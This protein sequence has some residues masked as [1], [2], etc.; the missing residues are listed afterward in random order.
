MSES[1]HTGQAIEAESRDEQERDAALTR[2]AVR[3]AL[4]GFGLMF[5]AAAFMWVSIGP[6]I[7]ID[8]ATAVMNCF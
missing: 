6:T 7:F 5:V 2:L 4:G 1:V 3:M 8:L